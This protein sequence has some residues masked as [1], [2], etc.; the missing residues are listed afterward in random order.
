MCIEACLGTLTCLVSCSCLLFLPSTLL[1]GNPGNISWALSCIQ[2]LYFPFLSAFSLFL[3]CLLQCPLDFFFLISLSSLPHPF[4]L[5]ISSP[6]R[7][8]LFSSFHLIYNPTSFFPQL[9]STLPHPCLSLI[10]PTL[11]LPH[12]NTH[13]D[14][15]AAVWRRS[16]PARRR[17]RPPR[18][19]ARRGQ[20]V[21]Q[22]PP[23]AQ[24][25]CLHQHHTVIPARR[26]PP[27]VNTP[28]SATARVPV[29][30]R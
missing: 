16:G 20:R 17:G 11:S 7:P 24:G 13:M 26:A 12:T 4:L 15:H 5:P 1:R 6:L 3:V 10:A 25:R 28:V 2:M 14:V 18:W 29:V 8:S 21:G 23:S 9:G 19:P 30:V 22:W 27:P